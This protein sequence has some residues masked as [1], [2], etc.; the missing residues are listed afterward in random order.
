M[1]VVVVVAAVVAAA[2][3]S[4]TDREYESQVAEEQSWFVTWYSVLGRL[5]KL[6]VPKLVLVNN[7]SGSESEL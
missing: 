7:E 6:R 4:R 1:M 3:G 2:G 5:A